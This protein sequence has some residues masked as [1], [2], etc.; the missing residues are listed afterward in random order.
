MEPKFSELY[1]EHDVEMLQDAYDTIKRLGMWEWFGKFEPHANEGFMFT[2]NINIAMI[3]KELKYQ[4]HSGASFGITM[5]QVHHIA[6]NGWE[7][8]K[9]EAIKKHGSACP[10]RRARGK[11]TRWCGNASGGVPACEY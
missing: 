1:D 10:C 5:R 11:A 8:H 9:N 3:G 6:K 7:N 2:S 4:D